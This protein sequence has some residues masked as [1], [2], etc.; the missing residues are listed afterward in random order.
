V[1]FFFGIVTFFQ[2]MGVLFHSSTFAF[3]AWEA[4]EVEMQ[5]LND[6]EIQLGSSLGPSRVAKMVRSCWGPCEYK[7]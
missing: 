2:G 1:A 7:K 3:G 5:P 4:K 6:L